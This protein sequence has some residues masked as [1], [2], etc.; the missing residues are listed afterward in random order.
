MANLRLYKSTGFERVSYNN[1]DLIWLVNQGTQTNDPAN[2][3]SEI[4]IKS[5]CLLIQEGGEKTVK[6]ILFT[7]AIATQIALASETAVQALLPAD[8]QVL[9]QTGNA[10]KN[11]LPQQFRMLVWNIHKAEAGKDWQRDFHHLASQ[12]DLTL[13][14]EGYWIDSYKETIE[15]LSNQLWSFA[16]SFIYNGYE[17]GVA[18]GSASKPAKISWLRSP[19]REPLVNSP[20]MTILSEMPLDQSK[21]S[22]LVA[23]IHGINF[24]TNGDFYDQ[25]DEV[26]QVI[27]NHRGP[28]IFAGD[29]NTW[30]PMRMNYLKKLCEQ[31]ELKIAKFRDDPRQNPIDHVFY[32]G[33]ELTR[34]EVLAT[35]KSSD[36]LPLMVEFRLPNQKF[37]KTADEPQIN[38]L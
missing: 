32:R 30:N 34:A 14:Q 18:I 6:R 7:I 36:H 9:K 35:I 31:L 25:L 24:V 17:T 38:E 13:I 33:L 27:K 8:D 12:S 10:N 22:L 11:N 2:N 4:G 20:K 29:F 26:V 21:D 28:L 15:Q 3:P 19:G 37:V 23:N 1:T 16:T 5:H